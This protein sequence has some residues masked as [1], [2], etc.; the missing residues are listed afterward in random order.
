M[1]KLRLTPIGIHGDEIKLEE[2]LPENEGQRIGGALHGAVSE[3]P[4]SAICLGVEESASDV[5]KALERGVFR[6]P[7]F[8]ERRNLRLVYHAAGK[9]APDVSGHEQVQSD[10]SVKPGPGRECF[11]DRAQ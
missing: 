10:I 1:N 8:R 11:E 5:G 9:G 7:R 3:D 2:L 4:K 6:L